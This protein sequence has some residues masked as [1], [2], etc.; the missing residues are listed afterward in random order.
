MSNLH[1]S[2]TRQIDPAFLQEIVCKVLGRQD[3][4]LLD[5]RCEPLLGGFELGNSIIRCQGT[6]RSATEL[7]PWSLVIK[8]S[9]HGNDNDDPQGVRYWR[10]EANAYQS[11]FFQ[12]M[13][14]FVTAPRYFAVVEQAS[15]EIWVWMEDVQD[16]YAN[17][18]P[19][20]HYDAVAYQLGRY[21]GSFLTNAP[22][23]D[24][25]WITHNFLRDYVEHAAPMVEFIRGH[26]DHPVVK[27]MYGGNLPLILGLWDTR[28]ELIQIL[29]HMPH[30]FCHQD[31]FKKNLFWRNG[32]LVAID[33]GYAGIAPLG[34]ELVPLVAVSLGL[35]K[36]PENAITQ[37]D[38]ICF[39][40]Y[41]RGLAD[42][43]VNVSK[44][45]VRRC[46]A[47]TILLRYIIGGN[48]GEVL[49]A[50]LDESLREHVE[51]AFNESPEDSAEIQKDIERYYQ[52]EFM[53]ALKLMGVKALI[54]V[55]LNTLRN[56]WWLSRQYH[57]TKKNNRKDKHAI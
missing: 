16:D 14:T 46:Y 56:W 32:Q 1:V 27:K 9:A 36:Q 28:H 20:Q 38:R 50:L 10:R 40:A 30:T 57:K 33:W 2:I 23:P 13:P 18:W 6:A 51:Q 3:I 35:G 45:S 31:A 7:L 34:A 42:A 48:I 22:L 24:E 21:N 19:M 15:G 47:L 52:A 11:G 44:L 54:W 53:E 29:D 49:P 4:T 26:L 41:L 25:G 55:A 17:D 5:W 37:L 39:S 12:R 43:G 8:V